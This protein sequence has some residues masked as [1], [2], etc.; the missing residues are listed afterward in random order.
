M[1]LVIVGLGITLGQHVSER[2]L[3]EIQ[4]ADKVLVLVD[5]VALEWLKTVRPDLVSLHPCYGRDKSR[6]LAYQDMRDLIMA[7]VRQGFKVCCV[8]YGH[9]G[10]F[11]D[12]PHMAIQATRALGLE[13]RMDPG[14]S[15]EACL[16]ADLG[17]DPG[18]RGVASM[19][20]TQFLVFKRQIDPSAL[21]LLWQVGICG[22]L[23]L[24]RF[25]TQEAKLALLVEKLSQ[26]YP[27]D[28]EVI[29]YEAAQLPIQ[30][31]RA[32]RLALKDLPRAQTAQITTLVVPP[33]TAPLER[34][35]FWL[36][37]LEPLQ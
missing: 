26:Y 9:P 8:F 28:H 4:N 5:G 17:L 32:Q 12:V 21:L 31:F 15:A 33:L 22:D 35:E 23:S 24:K 3:S 2:A 36:Q 16:Y 14:I 18:K 1:S 10:I 19:E 29:L 13:A 37:R 30:D 6:K 7:E 25:D 34:D 11:A 27:P 20:A